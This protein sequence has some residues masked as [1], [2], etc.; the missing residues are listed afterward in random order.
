MAIA[1]S[2]ATL[3][4]MT[5]N[6]EVAAVMI[7][8]TLFKAG[9]VEPHPGPSTIQDMAEG[10]NGEAQ[11][12]SKRAQRRALRG[13][14]GI[15][16]MATIN[17]PGIHMRRA[18][19]CG[20]EHDEGWGDGWDLKSA[21]SPKLRSVRDL[22]QQRLLAVTAI[23]E[24][25]LRRE[26]MQAVRGYFRR[27]GYEHTGLPG[28]ESETGHAVWG[29]SI[30]WDSGRLRMID[31]PVE[32]VEHRVVR[33]TLE[34]IG[35]KQGT[36]LTV[37]GT[38]MPQRT[39][40]DEA[41]KEAWQALSDDARGRRDVWVLGDLNAEVREV[42]NARKSTMTEAD[43]QLE[44]L[45]H[46]I[47]LK[48]TGRGVPT[49]RSG[50]EIDHILVNMRQASSTTHAEVA[51]GVSGRDHNLVT[52][53]HYFE[54][55]SEGCG[56]DREIG[57]RIAAVSKEGWEQYTKDTEAWAERT[58]N[59]AAYSGHQA[60]DKVRM[61]QKEL[62]R[63]ATAIM[64]QEK[65][66]RSG[67][68]KGGGPRDSADDSGEWDNEHDCVRKRGTET[69]GRRILH[70]FS[71]PPRRDDGLAAYARKK[72]IAT[73]EID[74]LVH[75]RRG[76]LL[77]DEVFNSIMRRIRDGEYIAAVI[78][79]PCTTFSVNRI[80]G[81]NEEGTGAS[82]IRARGQNRRGLPDLLEQEQREADNA[83]ILVER[84]AEIA[85]AITEQNGV[86]I[87]EN[88]VDRGDRKKPQYYQEKWKDHAPLWE[89]DEI[90]ELQKKT[91]AKTVD[92]VQCA[93]PFNG[94]YQKA[95]T[96][97]YSR[98]LSEL[99]ALSNMSCTH[100]GKG[101]H[102]RRARGEIGGTQQYMSAKAVAYPQGMNAHLIVVIDRAKPARHE[103]AEGRNSVGSAE[104]EMQTT[105][106]TP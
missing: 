74:T 36:R 7:R 8:L 68:E 25:R 33:I 1:A 85:K 60:Q 15:L 105:I 27:V 19:R 3:T 94:K 78:G 90:C 96:L 12:L 57:P 66:A 26:E 30:A 39:G 45:M 58:M 28:W 64:E 10:G 16:N 71:G 13:K 88:P 49:H 75:K 82:Q 97:M 46:N 17:A 32:I 99:D 95:T 83:N 47:N 79:T 54:V 55:D 48:R 72:G 31:E 42:K 50:T 81:E 56:P 67:S 29:V 6:S 4:T 37:Y 52:A 104:P 24:T 80:R 86:Y 34:I 101:A 89:M 63:A 100:R 53:R 18:D 43:N 62:M 73:D 98:E 103:T 91:H 5:L 84:S 41:V 65:E 20:T 2:C 69:D 93:E 9:D 61:I 21:P 102:E 92:F 70:L 14:G 35:D 40:M 11:T 23:T 51:P 106:E 76:N 77:C 22:M 87:I 44:R 38:Y 59:T